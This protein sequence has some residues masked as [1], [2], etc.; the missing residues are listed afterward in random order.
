MPKVMGILNITPDS[1]YDG[2]KFIQEKS[3][4]KQVSKMLHEGADIIDVGAASS[5]PGAKEVSVKTEMKRL[6]PVIRMLVKE[7]PGAV[8]S[9]DTFRSEIARKAIEAGVAIINDISGGEMDKKMFQ[10]VADLKAPYVLMHMKGT[11]RTMQKNPVYKDVVK[12]LIDFFQ[13]K[14]F[15]LRKAGVHDIM[16]DPGYGFGKTVEHNYEILSKLSLFKMLGCPILVGLSRKSIVNKVLRISPENALT[17]T[18]VLNTIALMNGV[19][20]LRVHDVKEAVEAIALFMQY[21]KG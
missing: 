18:T 14:I 9:V 19:K 11:S 2:G 10:T 12:E 15:Q 20:I 6:L 13:K 5:R 8:F 21:S 4:I 1:F 7:F 16:I 3:I 17:G